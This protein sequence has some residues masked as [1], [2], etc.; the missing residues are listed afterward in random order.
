L[1]FGKVNVYPSFRHP[2]YLSGDARDVETV[3]KRIADDLHVYYVRDMRCP[4]GNYARR[5]CDLKSLIKATEKIMVR[6]K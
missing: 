4:E 6:E 1:N 3:K 5:L 2:W